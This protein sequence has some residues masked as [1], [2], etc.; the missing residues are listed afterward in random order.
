MPFAVVVVVVVVVVEVVVIV[1]G[2]LLTM[3]ECTELA[4]HKGCIWRLGPNIVVVSSRY[5]PQG[6][7]S[8]FVAMQT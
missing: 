7:S 4:S 1:V 5:F 6:I 3:Q 2:Y 8:L